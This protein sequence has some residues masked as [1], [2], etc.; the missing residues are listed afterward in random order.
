MKFSSWLSKWN[1][2]SIKINAKI[3]EAELS[4]SEVDKKAAWELY[5]ELLTRVTTQE[6]GDS[7]GDEETALKSIHSLFTT[8][9]T[10]LKENGRG[11]TEFT[12][13]AIPILNQVVR[14]FT[15]EWHRIL[16]N[17][18]LQNKAIEFRKD[19]SK[20]QV[21]LKNY[22]KLLSDIAEVEDLTDL[23]NV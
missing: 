15:A 18:Q 3:I 7:D 16:I 19:L 9:R 14:P 13:I 23:E 20:L 22:A 4:F 2:D 12:K 11:C 1:L 8:T 17:N 6:L 21:I 5:I 10:I